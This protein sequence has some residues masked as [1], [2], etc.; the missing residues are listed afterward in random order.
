QRRLQPD[1]GAAAAQ[2][3]RTDAGGALVLVEGLRR[4][5]AHPAR[6]I[7]T[8]IS[9]KLIIQLTKNLL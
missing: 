2:P 6:K 1:R 3:R 7:I 5:D 8:R 4:R 9:P